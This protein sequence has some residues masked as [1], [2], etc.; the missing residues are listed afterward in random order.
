MQQ[1][2][3]RNWQST[4][5]MNCET[6]ILFGCYSFNEDEATGII[7]IFC[8]CFGTTYKNFRSES[9]AKTFYSNCLVAFFE[10]EFPINFC[11]QKLL[12]IA[13]ELSKAKVDLMS[14][15]HSFT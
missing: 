2:I 15:I 5:Q 11:N 3:E 7:Y 8:C 14:R 12:F 4:E 9:F 13:S 10:Q 6:L 1:N